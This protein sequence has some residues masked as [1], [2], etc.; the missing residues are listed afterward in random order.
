VSARGCGEEQLGDPAGFVDLPVVVGGGKDE[1]LG[2]GTASCSARAMSLFR[3]RSWT[4]RIRRMGRGK[5]ASSGSRRRLAATAGIVSLASES[6]GARL[7]FVP[8]NC[9]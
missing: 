2:S 7:L 5:A 1:E 4:P 9:S 8:K 6:S 3:S